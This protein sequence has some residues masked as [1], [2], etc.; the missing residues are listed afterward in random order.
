MEITTFEEAAEY[1]RFYTKRWLIERFHYVLKS[2]CNVEKAQLKTARALMNLLCFYSIIAVEILYLTYLART[3]P[4]GECSSIF[5]EH[6][7]KILY[8][9]AN[10]TK[11]LPKN[12]PT[13][14]EAII[15]L[16]RMGGF[17][18]RKNDGFPGVKVLWQGISI[19]RA[20][21]SAVP[22]IPVELVGKV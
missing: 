20:I 15:L 6:E 11:E 12:E 4:N 1:L 22:F 16:A 17:L 2:G 3:N 19:F 10:K 7:W 9:V 14:L 18:A 8:C 13:I 21:I 5:D